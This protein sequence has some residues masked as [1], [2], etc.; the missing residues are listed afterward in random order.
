M[1][2]PDT[3]AELLHNAV[4]EAYYLHAEDDSRAAAYGSPRMDELMAYLRDNRPVT[5]TNLPPEVM[6]V[7]TALE[8][9]HNREETTND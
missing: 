5:V 9:K 1:T 6:E 8:K 3:L 4:R 2:S 7:I